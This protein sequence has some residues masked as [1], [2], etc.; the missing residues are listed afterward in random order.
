MDWQCG[1][2][3]IAVLGCPGMP[4]V[5]LLAFLLWLRPE[6]QRDTG[7]LANTAVAIQ[8]LQKWYTPETGLWQTTNWWNAANAVTVLARYSQLSGSGRL[9]AGDREHVRAQSRQEVSQR[10]LRRRR[11]VGSGVGRRL[12]D[13]AR[14]A[15][16]G[17]VQS[18]LCR[19]GNGLGRHVGGG[20]VKKDKRY[21]N[22][23]ANE[24]FYLPRRNWRF[25]RAIR[26]RRSTW[27]G[28]S[29]SGAGSI[30]PA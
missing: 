10:I 13:V 2:P 21:K 29:G 18:H 1:S 26:R 5:L 25:W 6:P 15:L 16:P 8:A 4:K 30:P 22:A 28:R 24:L 20:M 27:I 14:R 9:P 3:V 19:Y 12:R 7:F 17:Y 23:I 11:V